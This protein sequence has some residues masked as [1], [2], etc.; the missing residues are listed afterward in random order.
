MQHRIFI[1]FLLFSILLLPSWAF[2]EPQSTPD[3]AK[4]SLDLAEKPLDVGTERE[5]G[6]FG[7]SLLLIY[8]IGLLFGRYAWVVEPNNLSL[9]HI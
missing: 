2:A 7:A 5:C 8:I 4:T 6:A 3:L 9:I 1:F